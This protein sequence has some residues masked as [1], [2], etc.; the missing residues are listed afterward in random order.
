[1][2]NYCKVL[3]IA[4]S[5]S[6]GGAGIQADLKT[7]AALGVYGMSVITAVTA[8]N[9]LG[10]QGIYP[11]PAAFVGQQ[12]DAIFQDMGA[13]AVKIGMLH[14]AEIMEI[15]AQKLLQYKVKNIVLDPVMVASSG[16][17]LLQVEAIDTLKK[18]LFP[19][20]TIITPNLPEAAILLNRR[21]QTMPDMELYVTDLT[22]WG[23][24]AALL[25]GGHL[26]GET[27]LD[28]LYIPRQYQVYEFTSPKIATANTHGTG[29]TLSAAIA[30]YI[31]MGCSITEAITEAR[32]FLNSA[33]MAGK[34]KVLGK[35]KGPVHHAFGIDEV[36]LRKFNT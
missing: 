6:G 28:I 10:V 1:M 13:D 25:K 30:A 24:E 5:D 2:K 4:G 20:A 16:D 27:C 15:V 17:S 29:C 14:S 9:T 36:I 34:D 7:F 32:K 8:Q 21:I 18:V 11:I 12:L 19:L 26:E 22:Q 31:A 33:L 35:G 3:T 23:S